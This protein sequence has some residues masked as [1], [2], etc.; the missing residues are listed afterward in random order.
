VVGGR[1]AGRTR[2]GAD[3]D[4]P[5]RTGGTAV[6]A[7]EFGVQDDFGFS[8]TILAACATPG[9]MVLETFKTFTGRGGRPNYFGHEFLP[10][11][12]VRILRIDGAEGP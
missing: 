4:E 9:I 11:C 1:S 10:R 6:G 8:V 7:V 5:H 12:G 3:R 2:F